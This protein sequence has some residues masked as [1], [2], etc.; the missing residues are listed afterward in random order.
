MVVVNSDRPCGDASEKNPPSVNS[1]KIAV[2]ISEKL[3]KIRVHEGRWERL[4]VERVLAV[5][6]GWRALFGTNN[7]VGAVNCA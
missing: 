3:E 7:S 6:I 5:Q 1:G 4:W 2:D